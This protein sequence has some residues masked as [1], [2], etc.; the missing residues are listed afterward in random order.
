MEIWY[1]SENRTSHANNSVLINVLASLQ[2]YGVWGDTNG[3]VSTGEASISLAQLCFPNAG[4]TGDNGHTQK[5]VLYIG[6]I[7]KTATPGASADWKAKDTKSFEDSIK[8]LGDSLV[9]SLGGTSPTGTPS[10]SGLPSTSVPSSTVAPTPSWTVSPSWD[11][12]GW[13]PTL[14]RRD[15]A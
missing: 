11:A 12:P 10:S 8:S 15:Q 9:A 13:K 6:F 3:G 5:D 4:I 14:W 2:Y 1:V 7:G